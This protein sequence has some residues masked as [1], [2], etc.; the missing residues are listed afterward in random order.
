MER[1]L[2]THARLG[3]HRRFRYLAAYLTERPRS[4]RGEL[5]QA[6][7][8]VRPLG[9]SVPGAARNLRR[10]CRDEGVDV[11]HAHAPVPAAL[12]R[13]TARSI[14]PRPAVVTTEHNS[15]DCYRPPTRLANA[16]TFPMDDARLAVSTAAADSA[17]G[18]LARPPTQVLIHGLDP[19]RVPAPEDRV[20]LGAALR[21]E[22]GVAERATLVVTVA[23]HR[24]EKD[25][26][27]LIAAART[28]HDRP[29]TRPGGSTPIVIVAAGA[30][31]LL[32]EH[33]SKVD[34]AGLGATLNLLG[35]RDDVGTLM[36]AADGFVL[37]SRNEGLPLALMEATTAGLPVVATAVGGVPEVLTGD[38]AELLVAPGRPDL[39]AD[40]LERLCDPAV[41]R[42]LSAASLRVAERFDA[43]AA[44]A[45]Q[46]A[47]YARLAR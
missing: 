27:N 41:R 46:E 16:V 25:Y 31:P 29:A 11:V 12:A 42:R 36:A 17:P 34:A 19:D 22:L 14:R 13:L 33:R 47:I 10:L 18:W 43:R 45:A 28:L 15:W 7:V 39:L 37:A 8:E 23:N 4:L 3:D 40:A 2:V 26:D 5:E 35:H 6:G 24:P 30:G 32:D 1:L 44:V 21:R 9:A 20:S 38:A